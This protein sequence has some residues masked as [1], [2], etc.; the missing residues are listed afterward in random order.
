MISTRLRTTA[1]AIALAA[2]FGVV[3]LHKAG[4]AP[5]PGASAPVKATTQP[6]PPQTYELTVP[7]VLRGKFLPMATGR[8]SFCFWFEVGGGRGYTLAKAK[9]AA[10]I[11]TRSRGLYVGRLPGRKEQ[12]RK[13]GSGGRIS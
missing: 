10:R 6:S 11:G 3:W 2:A 9:T 12:W 13:I 5:C 1:I 4:A 8:Q 7:R